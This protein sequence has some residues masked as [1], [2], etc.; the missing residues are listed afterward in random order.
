M[1]TLPSPMRN[2]GGNAQSF[3]M[4]KILKNVFC[5]FNRSYR[6]TLKNRQRFE[7]ILSDNRGNYLEEIYQKLLAKDETLTDLEVINGY[8]NFSNRI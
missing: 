7:D 4:I 8:L 2:V 5:K 1:N 6:L 3:C